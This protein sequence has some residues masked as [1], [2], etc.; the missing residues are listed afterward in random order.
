MNLFF[1][2]LIWPLIVL[3]LI[4]LLFAQSQAHWFLTTLAF[5]IF[6][7]IAFAGFRLIVPRR[8]APSS[9]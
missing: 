2:K 5:A 3:V 9:S 1:E 8:T 7:I 6:N 4:E